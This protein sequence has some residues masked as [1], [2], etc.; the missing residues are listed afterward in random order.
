MINVTA[1]IELNL[2]DAGFLGA[3]GDQFADGRGGALVAAVFQFQRLVE[4][5]GRSQRDAF[6][7][8]MI[9]A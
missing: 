7:S 9:C 8:S 1:A 3:L 4:R 5:G 2:L 6:A